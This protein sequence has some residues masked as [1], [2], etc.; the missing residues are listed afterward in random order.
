MVVTQFIIYIKPVAV[1]EVADMAVK[2][3]ALAVDMLVAVVVLVMCIQL[4][5]L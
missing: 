2:Q 4:I 3:E 1:P 5:L